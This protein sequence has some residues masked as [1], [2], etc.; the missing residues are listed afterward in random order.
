M[1]PGLLD[2]LFLTPPDALRPGV[3]VRMPP[4]FRRGLAAGLAVERL[5]PPW[6]APR[7]L[8]FLLRLPR[9]RVAVIEQGP[10]APWELALVRRRC[11]KLVLDVD[12][13]PRDPASPEGR[14]FAAACAAA[15]LALAA[16]D[17][18][19]ERVRSH[20][21]NVVTLPTLLDAGV[22]APAPPDA[23]GVGPLRVGWLGAA[24]DFGLLAGPLRELA[25]HRERLEL[26]VVAERPYAGELSDMARS[27]RWSAALEPVQLQGFDCGLLPVSGQGEEDGEAAR[28]ALARCM[29]CGVVPIA[30]G[31]AASRAVLTPGTDGFLVERPGD[32]AA[33]VLRLADD[34]GLRESMAAAARRAAVERFGLERL[35]GRFWEAL[36]IALPAGAD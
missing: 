4:H 8:A 27:E 19:A 5:A 16:D 1:A 22:Y 11:A 7:R 31:T 35:G 14:R 12:R 21:P 13:A 33:H 36:G 15:D 2:V 32:W 26:R 34:P 29:A 17:R 3:C 25:P 23:A 20:Q 9:S 6:S 30:S 18:L 28:F 24:H 10:L